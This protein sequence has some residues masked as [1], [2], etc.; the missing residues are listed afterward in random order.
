MSGVLLVLLSGATGRVVDPIIGGTAEDEETSGTAIA[1]VS[2]DA[3]GAV[4]GTGSTLHSSGLWFAPQSLGIGANY[5]IK[6]TKVSGTNPSGS[7]LG[8]WLSLASARTWS[9][10]RSSIGLV[11]CDLSFEI[12][13]DAAGTNIVAASGSNYTLTAIYSL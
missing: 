1:S 3:D 10:T 2:F 8:T 12:A 6:A 7:A 4:T 9:L 5:W 13:A 11:T